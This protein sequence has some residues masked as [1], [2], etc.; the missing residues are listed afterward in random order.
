MAKKTSK[1][2]LPGQTFLFTG[3]LIEL[4]RA[5]AENMV[6]SN[7]GFIL[8]GVTEKLNYL[9][10]GKDAGSKLDKAKKIKSVKVL[11][12]KEFLKLVTSAKSSTPKKVQAEKK[13]SASKKTAVSKIK[14]GVEFKSVEIGEQIWMAENLNVDTFRNGDP[15]PEAKSDKAWKDAGEKGQ[16]AWR[17]YD[18]KSINGK[19][20]GKLYNW[21]AVNDPRGLAP[22]GWHVPTDDEWTKLIDNLGGEDKAG[23]KL[24]SSSGW[25]NDLNGNNE[26]GFSGLPGGACNGNGFWGIDERTSWWSSTE[27]GTSYAFCRYMDYLYDYVKTYDDDKEFG[28]S[29]RCLKV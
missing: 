3:T 2:S 11:K 13:I 25:Y 20:Y 4:T 28:F 24:K 16:P 9:V 7:G 22:K 10:V 1:G 19:K 6:K 21:Y 15:I 17:Y 23:E 8:S 12:E 18:N 5:E 26:S 14:S 29:V 27:L